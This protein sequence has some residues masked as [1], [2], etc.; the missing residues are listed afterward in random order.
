MLSIGKNG[1]VSQFTV[2]CCNHFYPR[3]RIRAELPM[4]NSTLVYN[5]IMFFNSII[6]SG[7]Q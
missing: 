1:F 7:G 3:A 4:D 2:F 5:N 6:T